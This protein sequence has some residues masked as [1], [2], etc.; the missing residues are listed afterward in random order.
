LTHE[1]KIPL[2]TAI[3]LH[4]RVLLISEREIC[5]GGWNEFTWLE[6]HAVVSE[7]MNLLK[8]SNFLISL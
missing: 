4:E 8:Y 7:V 1:E 6:W 3:A 5:V 2:K